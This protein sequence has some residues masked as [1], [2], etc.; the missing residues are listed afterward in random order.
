MLVPPYGS[1]EAGL[2][3]IFE[4]KHLTKK[5]YFLDTQ[6]NLSSFSI[7]TSL[8]ISADRLP[9]P[10]GEFISKNVYEGKLRSEH[11]VTDYSCVTFIDVW[12]GKETM[13]GSSYLVSGRAI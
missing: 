10:L 12:K 4:V 5:S 1:S 11:S 7:Q 6:C 8:I 9:V 2:E 3:T 13:Q